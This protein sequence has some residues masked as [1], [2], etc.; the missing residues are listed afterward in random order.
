MKHFFGYI[1]LQSYSL[2]LSNIV[3]FKPP[4]QFRQEFRKEKEKIIIRKI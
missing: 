2:E 1:I 3:E 4:P